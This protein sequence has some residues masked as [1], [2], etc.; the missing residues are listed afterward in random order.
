MFD[1]IL[2]F[3]VSQVQLITAA[4][5]LVAVVLELIHIGQTRRINKRLGRAGH[6]LQRYLN[7]VFREDTDDK[8][9]TEETEIGTGIR[10]HSKN[11]GEGKEGET[12][13]TVEQPLRSRQEENMRVTL[14]HKKQKKEEEL[15]DTVLQEIFD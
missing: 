5:I 2:T 13:L 3:A 14:A 12:H 6:W 4:L 7:V 9:E 15:L 10:I 1:Q 8:S 11:E